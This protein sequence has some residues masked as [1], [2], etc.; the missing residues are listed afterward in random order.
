MAHGDLDQLSLAHQSLQQ[1]LQLKVLDLQQTQDSLEERTRQRGQ[2]QAESESQLAQLT[3]LRL[4]LQ[5]STDAQHRVQQ[6]LAQKASSVSGIV[7]A[8]MTMLQSSLQYSC[9]L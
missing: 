4:E 5:S 8:V 2:L 7:L 9:C 1:Q 3:Q 6:E